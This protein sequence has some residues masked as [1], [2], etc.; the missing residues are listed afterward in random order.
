MDNVGI[1]KTARMSFEKL[2]GGD[3]GQIAQVLAMPDEAKAATVRREVVV[4][5]H[6]Q[7]SSHSF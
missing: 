6:G 7:I 5:P 1:G 2:L 4:T 3:L